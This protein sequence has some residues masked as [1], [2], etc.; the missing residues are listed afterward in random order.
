MAGGI[1]GVIWE[2]LGEANSHTSNHFPKVF[3]CSQVCRR[4]LIPSVPGRETDPPLAPIGQWGLP[5]I[6]DTHIYYS[7]LETN[8][9]SL[10]YIQSKS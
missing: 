10:R 6:S 1:I 7:T 2:E 4:W 8:P 3:R 5:H 9:Q